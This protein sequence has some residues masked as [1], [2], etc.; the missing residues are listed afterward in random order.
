MSSIQIVKI[1]LSWVISHNEAIQ[2][3]MMPIEERKEREKYIA[4]RFEKEE[5]EAREA[6]QSYLNTGFTLLHADSI[7]VGER[8]YMVYTLYKPNRGEVPV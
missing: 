7:T 8:A 1:P 5:T 4:K 2:L 3:E 6:L